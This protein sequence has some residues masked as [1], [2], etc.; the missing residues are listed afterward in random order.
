MA[1]VRHIPILRYPLYSKA[2]GKPSMYTF[3][4]MVADGVDLLI[5]SVSMSVPPGA[6]MLLI[7]ENGA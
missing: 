1:L 3:S 2:L 4:H 6:P 5:M 7:T